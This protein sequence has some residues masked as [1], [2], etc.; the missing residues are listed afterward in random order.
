MFVE[1][2]DFEAHVGAVL[3]EENVRV[4]ALAF[5]AEHDECRQSLRIGCGVPDVDAL[6]RERFA[7]EAAHVL[8]ADARQHRD[9]QAETGG[10]GGEVRGGAAEILGEA[11]HVFEPAA[12]LLPVQI[13]GGA[14]E[15]DQVER[16]ARH[17]F[18]PP[19]PSKS[20]GRQ[21]GASGCI[22]HECSAVNSGTV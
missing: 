9:A 19:L 12:E 4:R 13:D 18:D 8:V 3:A 11:L 14:P 17:F 7:H 16:A 20:R 6:A 2:A 22:V 5:D 10:A 1:V 21:K 15:A